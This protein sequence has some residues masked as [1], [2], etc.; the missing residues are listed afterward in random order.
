MT[1]QS[2]IVLE[3]QRLATE[4]GSAVADLLR[5]ALLV[6]TKLDLQEFQDWVNHE[7][8]GYWDVN[9]VPRYRQC[10]AEVGLRNPYHGIV[11]IAFASDE[12]ADLFRR[13]EVRDPIA[14]LEALLSRDG[15]IMIPFAAKQAAF[16]LEEQ[17]P[18]GQLPPVRTVGKNQ[19]NAIMDAVRNVILKWTLKLE[20][21]RILGEGLTFSD[22]E[23]TRAHG[24][25]QIR[26]ESFFGNLVGTVHGGSV[27][28][29]MSVPVK[30]GDLESLLAA[31]Q[32]KGASIADM[33]DLKTAIQ[34][35]P[36]PKD[37][38]HL[39]P[40][41]SAWLGRMVTEAASGAR[42]IAIETASSVLS[43]LI[44]RYYGLI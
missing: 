27:T 25:S 41:V 15:A 31:V 12:L 3:L 35:D 37:R 29:N 14:S 8:G 20:S 23:R 21:E 10:T 22:D 24:S 2:S 26:I 16:L 7:L 43:A 19:I 5:K 42:A 17:G 34:E 9:E 33:E 40:R 32:S 28:Q 4:P 1:T 30:P 39:G 13:V 38:M 6:A 44:C 18:I 11:P 36:T